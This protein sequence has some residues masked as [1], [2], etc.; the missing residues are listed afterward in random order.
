MDNCVRKTPKISIITVCYNSEKY[1]EE[2]IQSVLRQNYQ[3]VE[4]IIIDGG[5][6]DNTVSIIDK[7]R[8]YITYFVSEPDNGI[9]DAFNKGIRVA[10]GDVI[11]II[12]SDDLLEEGALERVAQEYAPSVDWYRGDCKVWNDHHY[13]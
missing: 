9:S 3:N 8:Q 2:T 4:Y 12:N 13:L 5:S 6:T 10:T 11:G 7:Y 1:L